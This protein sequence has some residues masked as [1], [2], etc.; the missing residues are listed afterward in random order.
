MSAMLAFVSANIAKPS[1]KSFWE[2]HGFSRAAQRRNK[3]GLSPPRA[4]VY[5][6]G[7]L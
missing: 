2:G 5:H 6:F 3:C 4:A 1:H 7:S